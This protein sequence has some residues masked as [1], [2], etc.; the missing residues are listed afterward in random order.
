M[1]RR[2]TV[3]SVGW[4][5]VS[6]SVV[7]IAATFALAQQRANDAP[8]AEPPA[9]ERADQPPRRA[10]AEAPRNE[11]TRQPDA[12]PRR[13]QDRDQPGA[14]AKEYHNERG[15]A[16]EETQGQGRARRPDQ[17]GI[18]FEGQQDL[19]IREVAPESAAAQAG[20]RA[21]DRIIS[22]NGRELT[23]QRRFTAFLGGM[24]GRRVPLVIERNGRQYTVQLMA[25]D[26]TQDG[27]WLGVY[28]QDRENNEQ[29]VMVT[30]VYPASPA[31]RA[32][33]RA[34]D[35][36][37]SV[38]NQQVESA[39]DLITL[40]DGFEPGS[41]ANLR[42]RRGDQELDATAVL[43]RRSDFAFQTSFNQGDRQQGQQFD[44]EDPYENIPPYAM[45]LEH[46][47]RMAEQHQRMETELRKLQDE[48]RQLR[49]AIEKK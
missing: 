41:K 42:L 5:I 26:A 10:A 12:A 14:E 8:P 40:L 20:L 34:G 29:G 33:V 22:V 38:N 36:L 17:I 32:G 31:A 16:Q 44:D 24:S 4:L 2:V 19:R 39:P 45:Q 7:C 49:E 9:E 6:S 37:L 18:T 21:N 27:P 11:R 15:P 28:L 30:H 23:D 46:D 13:P 25:G 35:I 47:R 1:T 48:V 43:A 3:H